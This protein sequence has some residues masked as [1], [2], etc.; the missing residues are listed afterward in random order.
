[1]IGTFRLLLALSVAAVATPPLALY[2]IVAMKT[3]LLDDRRVPR[4]W[5]R[6]VVRL[7]GLRI[8]VRGTLAAGRPLLIA[9]NHVSWMDIVVLGSL[10]DV[11]FIAK[12]EVAT[13]PIFGTFARFQRSIF[14]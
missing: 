4:T 11:H 6:M 12:A 1:M 2:Q 5:H 3:G 8:H 7:L 14:I 10:A 9:A 13:W